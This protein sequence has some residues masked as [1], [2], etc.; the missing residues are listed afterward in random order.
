MSPELAQFYLELQQFIDEGKTSRDKFKTNC[1]LCGNLT[2][3]CR[4][5]KITFSRELKLDTELMMSF[6]KE[7]LHL[8]Y[9]FNDGSSKS[10]SRDDHLNNPLRLAW[11]KDRANQCSQQ[12]P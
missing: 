10:Y 2:Y 9:P 11:I 12:T 1:G 4:Y 3:F 5:H 6:A 7:N 8:G